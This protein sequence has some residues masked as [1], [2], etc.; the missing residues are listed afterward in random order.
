MDVKQTTVYNFTSI[1]EGRAFN[2]SIDAE[3]QPQAA[4]KLLKGLRTVIS[5]LESIVKA[6]IKP[7]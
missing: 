3:S 2:F 6:H 1:V 4:E 7:N 5:E